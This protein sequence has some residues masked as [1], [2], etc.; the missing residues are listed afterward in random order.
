MHILN[1]ISRLAA[2]LTLMV[3]AGLAGAQTTVAGTFTSNGSPVANGHVNFSLQNCGVLPSAGSSSYSFSLNSSGVIQ[4][5]AAVQPNATNGCA[6]GVG[7]SVASYFQVI[8]Q[9]STGRLVWKRNFQVPVSGSAWNAATA[10][11]LATLPAAVGFSTNPNGVTTC[12]ASLPS[13]V[14]VTP[15][16]SATAVSS[17]LSLPVTMASNTGA[18]NMLLVIVTATGT[19]GSAFSSINGATDSQGNTYTQVTNFGGGLFINYALFMAKGIVG[20]PDTITVGVTGAT[21]TATI[22]AIEYS[23]VGTTGRDAFVNG[24]TTGGAPTTLSLTTLSANELV[25]LIG[26]ANTAVSATGFTQRTDGTASLTYTDSIASSVGAQTFSVGSV[27]GSQPNSYSPLSAISF[28]PAPSGCPSFGASGT[29]HS[30]GFVPDPGPVAGTTK[31]LRE[32]A[33]F[34][35]PPYP[36][37]FVGSGA[38]HAAGLVPDPGA[39]AGTTRMLRE[40]GSFAVPSIS[41]TTGS[42]SNPGFSA[43]PTFSITTTTTRVVLTGDISLFTLPAG[44][45]GQVKILCFAQDATGNHHVTAP[46][47]VRG[48]MS[49]GLTGTKWSCQ[50]FT[51]DTTDSLWL[52]FTAG[53]TNQ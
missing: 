18:G 1:R 43:T 23:H 48:F 28:F 51:Y 47:N 38:S 7:G 6:P 26:Y 40:D 13:F 15:T 52:S 53:S 8:L 37:P 10:S 29:N 41:S 42:A 17:S 46:T 9:D 16:A 4:T 39:T 22:R 21:P 11:A 50:G 19:T 25:V 34:A 36:S 14:Q 24:S 49:V 12:T 20:G 3:V 32:D 31:F 45:D 35:V 2:V 44:F 5:G 30:S 33:T 27:T